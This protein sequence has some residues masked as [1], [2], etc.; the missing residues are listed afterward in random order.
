MVKIYDFVT[1]ETST[2][3]APGADNQFSG[4]S[5]RGNFVSAWDGLN[6]FVWNRLTTEFIGKY[7]S[8]L[9]TNGLSTDGNYLT[10]VALGA[11]PSINVLSNCEVASL[12]DPGTDSCIKCQPPCN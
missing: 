8:K 7:S 11:F 3:N 9:T 2:L 4:V 5:L 1:E 10:T 6:V 12:Y